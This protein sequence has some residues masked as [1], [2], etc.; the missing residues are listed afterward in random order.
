[1]TDH[2]RR[3]VLTA[4]DTADTADDAHHEGATA[5]RP[6]S[7]GDPDR[8]APAATPD[9]PGSA[10]PTWTITR[11]DA[12]GRPLEGTRGHERFT[13]HWDLLTPS[14][15]TQLRELTLRRLHPRAA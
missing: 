3:G 11:R 6:R 2:A 9:P 5:T 10:E 8:S 1:M 13:L 15:R 14:E 12:D 4:L 7:T